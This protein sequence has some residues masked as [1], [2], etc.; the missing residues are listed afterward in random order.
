MFIMEDKKCQIYYALCTMLLNGRMGWT[1][2]SCLV[3][4]STT[5]HVCYIL[6]PVSTI[7]SPYPASKIKEPK[8]RGVK[9]LTLHYTELEPSH[10]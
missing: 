10:T 5:V 9:T 7:N 2:E 8:S 3:L 6:L 1:N 4:Y